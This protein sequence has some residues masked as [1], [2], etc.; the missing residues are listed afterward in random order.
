MYRKH[1]AV[2][3]H[4]KWLPLLFFKHRTGVPNS[5]NLFEIFRNQFATSRQL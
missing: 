4:K 1:K 2:T 3:I 5:K